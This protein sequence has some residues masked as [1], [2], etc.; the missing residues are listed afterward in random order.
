MHYKIRPGLAENNSTASGCTLFRAELTKSI[1]S[2][3][4][5][6]SHKKSGFIGWPPDGKTATLP[7]YCLATSCYIVFTGMQIISKKIKARGGVAAGRSFISEKWKYTGLSLFFFDAIRMG[8]GKWKDMWTFCITLHWTVASIRPCKSNLNIFN[9]FSLGS[10]WD[11]GISGE[12][13]DIELER[14]NE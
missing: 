2:I 8:S 14:S 1:S 12:I 11:F 9:Q 6:A 10:M 7:I 5:T 4:S 13:V 3:L